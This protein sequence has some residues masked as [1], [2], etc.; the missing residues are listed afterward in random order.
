MFVALTDFPSH[1]R[2]VDATQMAA[3]RLLVQHGWNVCSVYL[4]GY[5]GQQS[6]QARRDFAAAVQKSVST[7]PDRTVVLTAGIPVKQICP[8]L[9]VCNNSAETGAGAIPIPYWFEDQSHPIPFSARCYH[10]SFQGSTVSHP[11]LRGA[12]V[13]GFDGTSETL[14]RVNDDYFYLL[15]DEEQKLLKESYWKVLSQS[16]FSL[17]PRGD[18]PSSVR[19]YE[20]LAA[21]CIPVLLADTAQLPLQ[22]ILPWNDMIVR[23]PEADASVWPEYVREW[24]E[25]RTSDELVQVSEHNRRTWNAW[26][27]WSQLSRQLFVEWVDLATRAAE[28]R[29]SRLTRSALSVPGDCPGKVFHLLNNLRPRHYLQVN[30]YADSAVVAACFGGSIQ[31]AT[32]VHPFDHSS[33]SK[34][35]DEPCGSQSAP[36][37]GNQPLTT[38]HGDFLSLDSNHLPVDIDVFFYDGGDH[39][40]QTQYQVIIK[41]FPLLAHQAVIVADNLKSAGTLAAIR[42]GL[43]TVQAHVLYEWTLPEKFNGDTDLWW[44]GLCVFAIEKPAECEPTL[45]SIPTSAGTC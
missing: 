5:F 20:S 39:Q 21:G 4:D 36:F 10:A 24:T 30:S 6:E 17:C 11:S 9:I 18:N 32:V 37:L 29:V 42:A 45:I 28:R 31:S 34:T 27:H 15:A 16:Q 33:T 25:M 26:F 1:A 35:K 40:P 43:R 8:D 13:R 22:G 19:F 7:L 14:C 2:L 23:V 3:A 41:V 12:V 38:I 44:K